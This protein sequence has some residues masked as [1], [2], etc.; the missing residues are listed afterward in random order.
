[1]MIYLI[2]VV[3]EYHYFHDDISGDVFMYDSTEKTHGV[4]VDDNLCFENIRNTIIDSS[5]F[6]LPEKLLTLP[7][8]FKDEEERKQI[9]DNLLFEYI[10][11]KIDY[12]IS[13]HCN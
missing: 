1:M 5:I 9:L 6:V 7:R 13:I 4:L 10:I 2:S 3:N 12:D 8:L 11:N